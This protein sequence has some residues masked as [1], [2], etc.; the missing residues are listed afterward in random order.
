MIIFDT[1]AWIEYFIGSSKGKLVREYIDSQEEILTPSICV[2]E[3]KYR[4][5]KEN[6]KWEERINFILN[7]SKIINLTAD[8][9]LTAAEIKKM[10]DL[11]L[12]DALIYATS[13]KLNAKLLTG[14][15][16]FKKLDNIIF[17]E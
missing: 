2:A 12:I 6:N 16:H 13:L 1:Y 9:A 15:L 14:D 7:R 3:V 5:L 4:Y 11:Y 10:Y 8:I 17:L